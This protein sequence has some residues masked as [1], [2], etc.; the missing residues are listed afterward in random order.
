MYPD[1]LALEVDQ[2]IVDLAAGL[3]RELAGRVVVPGGEIDRFQ[4]VLSDRHR[5]QHGVDLAHLQ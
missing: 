2:R 1:F 5:R 4:P 3:H